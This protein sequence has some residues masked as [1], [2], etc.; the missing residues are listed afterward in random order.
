MFP[1]ILML[2]KEPFRKQIMAGKILNSNVQ[3]PNPRSPERGLSSP[4]QLTSF[5]VCALQAAHISPVE[6]CCGLESPR[7][8]GSSLKARC[9]NQMTAGQAPFPP[10]GFGSPGDVAKQEKLQNEPCVSS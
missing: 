10:W 7:S 5:A 6:H 2:R 3:P 9:P 1:V 8:G 4:Q